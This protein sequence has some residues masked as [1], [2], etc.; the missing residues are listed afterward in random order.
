MAERMA[1]MKHMAE[2]MKTVGEML[3][4]R[5]EFDAIAVC[6]GVAAL[7]ENRH[8]ARKQFSS[9]TKDHASRASAAVWEKPD[10]FKAELEG[11]D[12][13]IKALVAASETDNLDE[14]RVPFKDVGQSCSS[15]HEQFRLSE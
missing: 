14:M 3:N 13:A 10:D 9:E 8:Q 4:G 7:H 2:S 6:A 11:F 5:R 1:V 15:C 12:A